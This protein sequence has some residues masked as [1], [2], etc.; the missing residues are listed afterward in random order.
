MLWGQ[1]LSSA[2][3]VAQP[4]PPRG[5]NEHCTIARDYGLGCLVV[6]RVSELCQ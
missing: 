2:S 6:E 4:G 5:E 3:A 1:I